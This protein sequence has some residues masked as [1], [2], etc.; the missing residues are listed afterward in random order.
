MPAIITVNIEDAAWARLLPDAAELAEEAS[1]CVLRHEGWSRK[2]VSIDITLLSDAKQRKLNREWRD[3]DKPTNVLSFPLE[4]PDMPV[5]KGRPRH[6]GDITL[7]RQ[8]L[9]REAKEQDKPLAHHFVH[10]VVHGT[11]HLLGYDHMTNREAVV[12]EGIEIKLLK[13]LGLPNPYE[14]STNLRERLK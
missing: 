5:P 1:L 12:M 9:V 7:A 13:K 3:K 11:L 4:S 2:Q 6:F 10:L 8:T 14:D